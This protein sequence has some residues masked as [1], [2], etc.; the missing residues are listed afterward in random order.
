MITTRSVSVS[1]ITFY[2][3]TYHASWKYLEE[4][5]G[6]IMLKDGDLIIVPCD[7][8]TLYQCFGGSYRDWFHPDDSNREGRF[9]LTKL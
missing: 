4:I 2:L 7:T 8:L 6:E 9:S 3:F 5:L 1:C